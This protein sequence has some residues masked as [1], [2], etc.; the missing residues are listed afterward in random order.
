MTSLRDDQRENGD[1]ARIWVLQYGPCWCRTPRT[2]SSSFDYVRM[3]RTAADLGS[4]EENLLVMSDRVI[5]GTAASYRQVH[6][7][8]PEPKL[9]VAVATCPTAEKFWDELPNGWTPVTEILPIDIHVDEC[10]NG[11]PEALTAAVL[12]HVLEEEPPRPDAGPRHL[13][14]TADREELEHA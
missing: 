2:E 4:M 5:D 11:K 14:V 3:R 12:G 9:V 10:I 6:A 8:M 7:D 13:S 1:L